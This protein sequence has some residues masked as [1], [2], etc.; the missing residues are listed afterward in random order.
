MHANVAC[1][2]RVER[3]PD[4]DERLYVVLLDG[5]AE[6]YGLADERINHN[7]NEEIEEDLSHDDLEDHEVE[8]GQSEVS[9]AVGNS[10]ISSD[11]S[12]VLVRV[13]LVRDA[14]DTSGVKHN[15]IPSFSSGASQQEE[16]GTEEGLEIGMDI[17]VRL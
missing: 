2:V 4:L 10:T 9:T 16:E 12:L 15:R 8:D 14:V 6:S 17:Q 11:G 13:A 3:T 1:G 5:Q 7:R